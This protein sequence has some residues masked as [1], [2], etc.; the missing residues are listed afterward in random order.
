MTS[1][2]EFVTLASAPG[3][4][5]S[6]LC[7]AFGISRKTAYKWLGLFNKHGKEGLADR[8]R[9]PINSPS[10]SELELETRVVALHDENPHW[11]PDKLLALMPEQGKRPH[12]NTIRAIL[13]RH[14]RQVT[15][16]SDAGPPANKR[17]EHEASNLLWQMDFKGHFA[18]TDPNAGRCYPLT[19]I[20]D[21]SRFAI[22]LK[23][24]AGETAE[25]ARR[26]LIDVFR[27]FGLPERFTCDNGNPWGTPKQNGLTKFEV[28]LLRLGI[29]VSHS[30]PMHPQTQGKAERF[31]RTL[32]HELLDRRGFNSLE[33]CQ[34]VFDDWRER[35]NTIRPHHA[36]GQ[37][38]P[39]TR[40][41]I[42]AR[43]YPEVLPSIEYDEGEVVRKVR[44]N[45]HI[46]FQ[47]HQ[48]FVGEG[49]A[50]EP[51]AIRHTD[52][53]GLLSIIF[54][55]REVSEIDLRVAR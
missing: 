49:L 19:I 50:G 10:R 11:G 44:G 35:Y 24:C 41:T 18:L 4:N 21:H 30:R 45:G 33:K 52:T 47:G 16:S 2:L 43:R 42:S 23:A 7:Q 34:P 22:C 48:L 6:A 20:D 51:V 8:S 39:A 28:W 38:P 9:R 36:L 53:D 55:N 15:P 31:H 13:R 32:K 27:Q 29:R 17:F 40:Y 54:C 12:P 46:S 3:A 37:K 26:A 1:R 25:E 5:I 14:G